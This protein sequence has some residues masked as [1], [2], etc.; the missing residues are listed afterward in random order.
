MLLDPDDLRIGV[1]EDEVEVLAQRAP[2]PRGMVGDVSRAS[3]PRADVARQE[4]TRTP[5]T[6]PASR[7]VADA[8]YLPFARDPHQQDPDTA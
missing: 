3:V 4:T 6:A 7:R 5:R 2:D 8:A 1:D